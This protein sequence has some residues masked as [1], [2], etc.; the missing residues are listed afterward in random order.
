MYYY[1]KGCEVLEKR[2]YKSSTDKI[3]DGVCGGIADYF[4]MD[5]SIVRL[6]CV[7]TAF[8]GGSGVILYIIAAII[9]PRDVEIKGVY[10]ESYKDTETENSDAKNNNKNSRKALGIILIGVGIILFLRRFLYIFNFQY[11]WPF[12]LIAL[13]VFLILREK[14]N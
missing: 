9:L 8:A 4:D 5:P 10:Q 3:I 13:G 7:A 11:I 1:S 2:L 14:R 6:I 12:V